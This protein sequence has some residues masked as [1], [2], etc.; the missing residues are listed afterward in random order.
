MGVH[1]RKTDPR[2]AV[3][4]VDKKFK[5]ARGSRALSRAAPVTLA[6]LLL[7]WIFLLVIMLL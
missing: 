1:A 4:A 6:I 3:G 7:L 2:A 5:L